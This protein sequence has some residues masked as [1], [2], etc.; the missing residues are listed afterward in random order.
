MVHVDGGHLKNYVSKSV[1]LTCKL[2]FF[3]P[4]HSHASTNQLVMREWKTYRIR[5]T[6]N[7]L[8]C[9]WCFTEDKVVFFLS[10]AL[11]KRSSKNKKWNI[12][13][14]IILCSGGRNCPKISK[15][16]EGISIVRFWMNVDLLSWINGV[17]P[18]FYK[19]MY[20]N[21]FIEI[22]YNWFYLWKLLKYKKLLDEG[23]EKTS[24]ML[25]SNQSWF[26][27]RKKHCKSE[28]AKVMRT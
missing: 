26:K 5:E 4:L 6:K 8:S 22:D 14:E 13:Q 12:W 9:K 25:K 27:K 1:W 17:S 23:Q 18:I 7:S 20:V 2:N 24:R 21:S 28:G 16:W 19:F 3:F 11:L 10:S 15:F